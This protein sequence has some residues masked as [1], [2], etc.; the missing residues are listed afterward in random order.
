MPEGARILAGITKPDAHT[1][2]VEI[3]VD[4]LGT[5]PRM[6]VPVRC[7]VPLP[8]GWITD[9]SQMALQSSNGIRAPFQAAVTGYWPDGSL[10]WLNLDFLAD[11]NR[12][13]ALIG[14]HR[15]ERDEGVSIAVEE[16][17]KTITINTGLL[18]LEIPKE[19]ATC[20]P[21]RVWTNPYGEADLVTEGGALWVRVQGEMTGTF[22]AFTTGATLEAAGPFRATVRLE[23]R[24]AR[25]DGAEIDR[26][27]MRIHA[28]AGCDFLTVQHSFM[29]SVDVRYTDTM[30]VGLS[31]RIPD[32]GRTAICFGVDGDVVGATAAKRLSAVQI[33]EEKP[34]FPTFNQFRPVFTVALD[35][36]SVS[37]GARSDGWITVENSGGPMAVGLRNLW[38]KH[39]GGFEVDVEQKTVSVMI[40][41]DTG[42]PY[43][44]KAGRKPEMTAKT[45]SPWGSFGDDGVGFT[46][47][48]MIDFGDS[49]TDS[50]ARVQAFCAIPNAYA[51]P[52]WLEH[53]RALGHLPALDRGAFPEAE[54]QLERMVE[55]L[56]RHSHEYFH[57]Y[58][59]AWG[60]IQTHY[61][62]RS[63][64]WSDLTERYAWLNAEADVAAGVLQHYVRTG[65]RKAFLLGRSMVRHDQDVGTSHRSGYGRRHYVYAWGQGG[66]W[67]HTQLFSTTIYYHL[68][69]C[70]RTRDI[71]ELTAGVTEE[72]GDGGSLKRDTHNVIRCALWLYEITGD[73]K[74][75]R[76]A[77]SIMTSTLELQSENGLFGDSGLMTNIYLF[78]AMELYDRLIGDERVRRALIRC[79]EANITMPGR[80]LMGSLVHAS[81]EGLAQAYR[82]SGGDKRFLWSGLRDLTTIRWTSIYERYDPILR[83]PRCGYF[84]PGPD[85]EVAPDSFIGMHDVGHKLA[86]LPHLMWAARDAGLTE[87]KFSQ[88]IDTG[89]LGFYMPGTRPYEKLDE[90]KYQTI[91]LPD[92]NAAPLAEDPFG[93][94]SGLNLSGLPW[95]NTVVYGGVPFSLAPAPGET[96]KAV[97]CVRRGESVRLPVGLSASRIHFLGQVVANAGL[98]YGE[99]VGR[100][101]LEFDEGTEQK[102]EWRNVAD[103]EDW[104]FEHY[105]VAAP[106]AQAWPP[107]AFDNGSTTLVH[108]NTLQVDT[109]GRVVKHLRFEAGETDAGPILLAVTAELAA[110]ATRSEAAAHLRFGENGDTARI[111]PAGAYRRENGFTE[112]R[113]DVDRCTIHVPVP[114]PGAYSVEAVLESTRPLLADILDAN[115]TAVRGWQ[116]LGEWPT[117]R[118]IQHIVFD[119]Q[120]PDDENELNLEIQL[121]RGACY[122][123]DEGGGVAWSLGWVYDPRVEKWVVL[124]EEYLPE[125]DEE[126]VQAVEHPGQDGAVAEVWYRRREKWLPSKDVEALYGPK[127]RIHEIICR[128]TETSENG[129]L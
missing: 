42:E 111:E 48:I 75:R 87:G 83:F 65:S 35:G 46:D 47:E 25:E 43:D 23:G 45:G 30:A 51:D 98:E 93:F 4:G 105:S 5:E 18:K 115:G 34:T 9:P 10:K 107:R 95:G 55:W 28:Y 89:Q 97:V 11:S 84:V 77:E 17:E 15:E 127:L 52:G 101:V 49:A 22:R 20:F 62:P 124:R 1:Q 31:F 116:L 29:N 38:Q 123:S 69:A 56:W 94:G 53:T 96:D 112:S 32:L 60:G 3:I 8:K 50:Q 7:G 2:R 68:T 26:W 88:E 71:I 33:N 103:C 126:A 37:E 117:G 72:A 39:P 82:Y 85:G 70:G 80:L 14:V 54:R 61:Q 41:P 12:Y 92:C 74:W 114:A 19:G 59:I 66:D 125:M 100:Y 57:W 106:L 24:Y 58:G 76:K 104:R 21:G 40:V 44:W 118:S 121:H 91:E 119:A 99:I 81:G 90:V 63:G 64:H 120:T 122:Y 16:S 36:E 6:P 113:G 13:V 128:K 67:P 108:V 110:P 129:R 86:K 102:V 78:W 79:I 73:E 109:G 27:V